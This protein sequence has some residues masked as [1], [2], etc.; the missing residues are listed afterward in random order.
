MS[1][2]RAF[3]SWILSAERDWLGDAYVTLYEDAPQWVEH[4]V[5]RT[6]GKDT[7]LHWAMRPRPTTNG[8]AA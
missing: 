5:L 4:Q 1:S 2:Q 6:F 3:T 7:V 8:A